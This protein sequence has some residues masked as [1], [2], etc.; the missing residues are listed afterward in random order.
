MEFELCFVNE[1]RSFFHP[2]SPLMIFNAGLMQQ[3]IFYIFSIFKILVFL[4]LM[5]IA[6]Y[7]IDISAFLCAGGISK[8]FFPVVVLRKNVEEVLK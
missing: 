6:C 3:S 4:C 7:F 2:K 8:G 1:N 5:H